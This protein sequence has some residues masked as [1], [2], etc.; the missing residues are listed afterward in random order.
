MT[1]NWYSPMKVDWLT[2]TQVAR[3]LHRH[4]ELVRQWLVAGRIPGEKVAGRWF[5]RPKDVTR[6]A[7]K[8]PQRRHRRAR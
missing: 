6:F 7:V 2:L 3:R 5:V 1:V 4:P 8:E